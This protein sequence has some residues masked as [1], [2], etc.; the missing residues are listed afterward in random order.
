LDT[1]LPPETDLGGMTLGER[2]ADLWRGAWENGATDPPGLETGVDCTAGQD[3][4]VFYLAQR[5]PDHRCDAPRGQPFLLPIWSF[6]EY[7]CVNEPQPTSW[8]TRWDFLD[9][10][11]MTVG[12]ERW[13]ADFEDL[14]PYRTAPTR[15]TVGGDAPETSPSDPC[16]RVAFG[17]FVPFELR[18]GVHT[19]EVDLV[20]AED[21]YPYTYNLT[22]E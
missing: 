10:A 22:V 7:G 12:G 20:I 3:G 2:G 11:S 5:A 17:Y 18:R 9:D 14:E 21:T 16:G 8:Q 6:A 15:F 13:I 4:E 19:I 1:L